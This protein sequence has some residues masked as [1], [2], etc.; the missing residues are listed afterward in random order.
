[1]S[2]NGQPCIRCDFCVPVCPEALQ[3]QQLYAFSR[4]QQHDQ[5]RRFDLAQ[6][7]EC[8]AC[9]AA[10]PSRLPLVAIFHDE[11]LALQA[12]QQADAEAAHWQQRFERHQ[13]RQTHDALA[14]QERKLRKLQAKTQALAE[15]KPVS[16]PVSANTETPIAAKSP[17]QIQ[18]EIAAA[19]ERTRARKAA[20]QNDKSG[21]QKS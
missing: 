2:D 16:R 12:Q 19:V 4:F 7:T 20:L 15:G 6:C 9:E 18:A 8:G 13:A 21:T 5:A 1:V 11:K 17:A 14:Q 10:C 3:P